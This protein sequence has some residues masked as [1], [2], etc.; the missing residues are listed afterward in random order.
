[1][2]VSVRTDT[3]IAPGHQ[4][5]CNAIPRT[6]RKKGCTLMQRV[7]EVDPL[8]CCP[9]LTAWSCLGSIV[10]RIKY[11]RLNVGYRLNYHFPRQGPPWT[12]L[13]NGFD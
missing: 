10:F 3:P 8:I 11:Y 12:V 1:M 4:T 13:T 9:A 5:L 6:P 2:E 7:L